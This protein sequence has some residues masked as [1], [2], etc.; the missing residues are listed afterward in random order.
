MSIN[1]AGEGCVSRIAS[2]SGSPAAADLCR[3]DSFDSYLPSDPF[4]LLQQRLTAER[5]GTPEIRTVIAVPKSPGGKDLRLLLESE[6]GVLILAEC[7]DTE[8]ETLI[9]RNYPDLIVL[10][11]RTGDAHKSQ[12]A[13]DNGEGDRPVVL[14]VASGAQ[15]ATQ[16]FAVHAV[17]FLVRPLDSLRFHQAMER[18]RRE[19]RKLEHGR[20]AHQMVGL[21]QQPRTQDRPDQ[22]VFRVDGRLIFVDLN[23]IDWIGASDNYVRVN[24]GAESYL[25]RESIG[26]LSAHLDRER[27]VRIHRSVIVNIRRIKELQSCNAG[28]YIA[29]L[30]NGKKLPCSRGFRGELKRYI[31]RC[32]R[33]ANTGRETKDL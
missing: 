21:L 27:F 6:P 25:V 7:R 23:D 13:N 31:S 3:P 14:C 26:R 12:W 28:E 29:V 20:L 19:L 4:A 18:V 11:I 32:I 17:D 22:L 16:A 33:T 15:Y 8:V 2:T 10:D 9:R 1:S 5:R 30:K 24:A